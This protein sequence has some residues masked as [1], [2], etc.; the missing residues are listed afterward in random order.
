[1]GNLGSIDTAAR[2]C[3]VSLTA[4]QKEQLCTYFSFL[5]KWGSRISLTSVKNASELLQFH[6]LEA[7]WVAEEFLTDTKTLADIG[8]GAGFPGLVI[9]LY[10]P[11]AHVYLIEKNYKKSVFLT[12]LSRALALRVGVVPGL[13]EDFPEWRRVEF[14]TMRA[15]RPSISLLKV[16]ADNEVS[17]LMFHG[18]EAPEYEHWKLEKRV[19]FPLS[20]NRWAAL[21]QVRAGICFT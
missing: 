13:A 21:Y 14:A 6:F 9:K 8:S 17:L 4:L 18:R 2:A 11:A 16:L 10:R 19:R 15:I 3:G 12:E 1:M 20:E 7:C 5:E